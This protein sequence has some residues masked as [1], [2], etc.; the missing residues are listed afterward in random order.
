LGRV[1]ARGW[2]QGADDGG[3]VGWQLIDPSSNL[4]P[5]PAA[6]L[7]PH[8]AIAHRFT[9][10]QTDDRVS[11]AHTESGGRPIQELRYDQLM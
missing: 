10:N 6:D 7:M 3:R 2:R 9:N 4:S 8:D 5:Q 1:R 11:L